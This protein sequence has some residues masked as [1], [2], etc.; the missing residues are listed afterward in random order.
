MPADPVTQF[1]AAFAKI[2]A[3]LAE[4]DLE[5]SDVVEI[6][7]YHLGLRAHFDL[8]QTEMRAVL[9][10][11]YPAWTA[12]EVAGLRRERALVELRAIAARSTV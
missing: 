1:R 11:P 5:L 4:A 6:T 10:S 9:S 2:A 12:V 8:F 7:S 3:V